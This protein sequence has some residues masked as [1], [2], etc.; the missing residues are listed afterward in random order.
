MLERWRRGAEL[1][2][3][4]WTDRSLHFE[5][6]YDGDRDE[7]LHGTAP[8]LEAL[9][10]A[11]HELGEL[12]GTF[13]VE[14]GRA[15]IRVELHRRTDFGEL[16][17]LGD[18]AAGAFDGIVR[19]PLEDLTA[20]RPRLQRVLRHEL[21]HAFVDAA[22][23]PRVPGWLNEGLAQWLEIPDPTQR[24]TRAEA[25]AAVLHGAP[26]I[27]LE[28]LH[29]SLS[30]WRDPDAI[31]RAYAQS[32]TLVARIEREFGEHLLVTMVRA[33]RRGDDA[34]A[35]FTRATGLDL[36]ALLN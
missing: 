14:E 25:A 7:L 9:E 21:V 3:A 34:H 6:A 10:S 18:W 32:L 1:E 20:E 24:P 36:V 22:G 8:L 11:Y 19:V 30:T 27:P 31:E 5:L 17:G 23:G 13:P 35:A 28:R 2:E 12:F 15:P 26:P 29:G 4:F 33:C 16:T